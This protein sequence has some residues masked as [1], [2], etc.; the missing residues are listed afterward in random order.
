MKEITGKNLPG[1]KC[2]FAITFE[3]KDVNELNSV[4]NRVRAIPGMLN[5]KRGQN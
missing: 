2:Q 5:V 4:M 3:V 1:T